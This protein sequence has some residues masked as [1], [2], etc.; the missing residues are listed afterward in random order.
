[1]KCD[2]VG[3]GRCGGRLY[4]FVDNGIYRCE[5]HLKLHQYWTSRT[6]S[7]SFARWVDGLTQG[8]EQR[9]LAMVIDMSNWRR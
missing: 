8:E 6:H 9:A 4:R 3:Y 2:L 5:R 7:S 1:M